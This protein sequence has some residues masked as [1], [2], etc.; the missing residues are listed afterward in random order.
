MTGM[1]K[2]MWRADATGFTLVEATIA[3][4]VLMFF[5]M[6]L[7]GLAVSASRLVS[8]LET[9]YPEAPAA[10]LYFNSGGSLWERRFGVSAVLS[11]TQETWVGDTNPPLR[12]VQVVLPVSLNR[13]TGDLVLQVTATDPLP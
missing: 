6:I 9:R 7:S 5:L 4:T 2:Q 11:P 1:H 10:T 12:T 8:S 13:V 3:L